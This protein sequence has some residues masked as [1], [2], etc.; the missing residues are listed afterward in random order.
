MT[1]SRSLSSE[2]LRA[3]AKQILQGNHTNQ[4]PGRGWIENRHA[5]ETARRRA[6]DD[7]SKWL[8]R[9]GDHG[10]AAMAAVHFQGCSYFGT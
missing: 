1:C 5:C 9:I 10:S 4:L 8:V 3:R 6:L 7:H 2:R